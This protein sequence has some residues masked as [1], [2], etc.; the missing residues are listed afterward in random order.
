MHRPSPAVVCISNRTGGGGSNSS[1]NSSGNIDGLGGIAP[2]SP[3]SVQRRW[4]PPPPPPPSPAACRPS[5]IMRRPPSPVAATELATAASATATD[6][7]DNDG[8]GG[9]VPLSP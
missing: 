3:Y 2:L 7:N 8:L 6:D 9:I 1:S 4:L 5:C